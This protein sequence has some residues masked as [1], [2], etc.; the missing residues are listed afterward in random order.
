MVAGDA[1]RV[2]LAGLGR[3]GSL[4]ASVLGHMPGVELAALCEPDA[5]SLNAALATY[6]T[7]QGFA[8]FD[9]MIASTPLDAVFIV[10]PEPLHATQA[11]AALQRGIAVFVEKP[12]AMESAEAASLAALAREKG[13]PLQVGFVLRFDVQHQLLRDDLERGML[14]EVVSIR[15]KRNVSR[16]WFPSFGDRAHPV[17]ET[18]IHD[19]DLVL[20]YARS[21]VTRV[22]AIER[23]ISGMTYPDACWAFI[24]FASGAVAI[25]E[26]SWFVP[27]GA[28]ANV[29]TPNWRGTIDAEIEVIGTLETRRIRLL[30][31][32]YSMWTSDF[33]AMPEI[34]MWPAIAGEVKGALR[35]EDAYFIARVRGAPETL[36]S[37]NDAITGLR[38]GEAIIESSRTGSAIDF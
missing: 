9:R 26:S 28:P 25:V 17:Q 33:T 3:F 38:I 16:A 22:H 4:H 23:N 6:Q 13:L 14:G 36:T 20:W 27:A 24:E 30:D 34:G 1:I 10:S 37:V 12:L 19:L 18:S 5:A 2:G 32:P 8:D 29:I 31:A 7:A 35:E 15:T 21:E 11:R